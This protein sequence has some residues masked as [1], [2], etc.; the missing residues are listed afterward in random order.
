MLL[1]LFYSIKNL[2]IIGSNK[3]NLFFFFFTWF[4]EWIEPEL[5]KIIVPESDL[6]L[7]IEKKSG[8]NIFIGIPLKKFKTN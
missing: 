6:F 1:W 7:V 2:S 8:K 4:A 5:G 3:N